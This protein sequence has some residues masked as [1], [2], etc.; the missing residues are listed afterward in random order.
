MLFSIPR[1]LQPIAAA[2]ALVSTKLTTPVMTAEVTVEQRGIVTTLLT[3]ALVISIGDHEGTST[4]DEVPAFL[5]V[6]PSR[7]RGLDHFGVWQRPL[8]IQVAGPHHV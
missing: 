2:I 7:V 8:T 3:Q 5:L 6:A 1:R 4:A